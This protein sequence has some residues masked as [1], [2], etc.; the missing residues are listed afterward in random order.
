VSPEFEIM[1]N[2]HHSVSW[3]LRCL[4]L[5]LIIANPALADD[6]LL[7]AP[8]VKLAMGYIEEHT[9]DFL[10]KQI[11]ICEIPAPTFQEQERG[12]FMAA[13]FRRIGLIDV[14]T[15]K[16]GNVLGW[17]RGKADRTLALCAHMDTV[18]AKDVD[19]S[20]RKE[21]NLYRG[22]GLTDNSVA[23]MALLALAEALDAGKIQTSHNLLFVASVCEEGLGDLKGVKF[24]LQEGPL[25]GKV[26]AFIAVE[27]ADTG[28]VLNRA[29]GS[30]RYRMTVSG[31]GG[32]SWGDFGRPNP[33]N[34]LGRIIAQ[35]AD[36]KVTNRPRTTFNVG[37]IGGGNSVN[38]I[39]EKAWLE[40]DMRS[41][42][43]VTLKELEKQVLAVAQ[44]EFSEENKRHNGTKLKLDLAMIGDRPSGT[45]DPN[46]PLIKAA[47]RASAVVGITPRLVIG[48]TDANTPI[49][50][51]IPSIAL[52]AGGVGGELH[53][54]NEW[55]M[56]K[57]VDK[58]LQRLLLTIVAYDRFKVGK[59]E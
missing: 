59:D 53:S 34:A 4:P 17:R 37:R 41:E 30:K 26:D 14:T 45:T 8:G 48:S 5:A 50:L 12:K 13:E 22:R 38:S 9:S 49:S 54:L 33:V 56:P 51:G 44:A 23:I 29:L 20:V 47:F 6:A 3:L 31:P 2:K 32:H 58:G 16:V 10:K 57:D 18:F 11:E 28:F 40:I 24:L 36:L 27:G 25:K 21:G 19:V 55:Y 1:K 43:Q 39:P 46:H 15:D 7:A 35:L 42:S 52:G